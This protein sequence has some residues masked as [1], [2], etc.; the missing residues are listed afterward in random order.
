MKNISGLLLVFFFIVPGICQEETLIS[1][2]LES[3][4][5]GGPVVKFTDIKNELGVMVGG[6]GGWIINHTFVL[7]GGG[8]G[9]A[10]ENIEVY[11][12][13]HDTTYYLTM[14]Y[15]GLELEYIYDS[16]KLVHFTM[17]ALI[18]AGGVDFRD[19]QH[20]YS[21]HD[22]YDSADAF[23]VFEPAA[24]IELNVTSFFRFDLGAS[25]RFVAGLNS[26][27]I[28]NDEIAG[29]AAVLTLKFGK[30]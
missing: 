10:N 14:G 1:G 26:P 27:L 16:D 22:N 3:G 5:F 4:G 17:T 25:Y 18:G 13:A 29:P 6:R 8:Y 24:N 28:S 11:D 9:L 12:T 2:K 23:F 20:D 21:R 30:F 7:G 19:R 15:G